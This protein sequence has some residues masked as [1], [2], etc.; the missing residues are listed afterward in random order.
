VT[1][2]HQLHSGDAP[3][4]QEAAIAVRE[5]R[6]FISLCEETEVEPSSEIATQLD[7]A[8]RAVAAYDEVQSWNLNEPASG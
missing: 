4:E 3:A 5:L 7:A 6:R 2:V 8:R 1:V